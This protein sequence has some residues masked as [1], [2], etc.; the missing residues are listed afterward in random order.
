MTD[1]KQKY[2]YDKERL[3]RENSNLSWQ[4]RLDGNTASSESLNRTSGTALWA[5]G[6]LFSPCHAR[7]RSASELSSAFHL[8]TPET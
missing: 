4:S 2:G 6:L 3:G 7:L 8:L 5:P 1:P